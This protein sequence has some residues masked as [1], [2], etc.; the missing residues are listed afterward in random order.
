MAVSFIGG[1][2][3]STG[4]GENTDL[5]EVIDELYHIMLYRVYTTIIQTHN[6][7]VIC[8]DCIG[9]CKSNYHMFPPPHIIIILWFIVGRKY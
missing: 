4:G 8:T 3:L 9:S 5:M 6:L 1:G 2:K 7:V